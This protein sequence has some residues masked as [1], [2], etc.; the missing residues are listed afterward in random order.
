MTTWSIVA[1]PRNAIA[2]I[3]CGG[4]WVEAKGKKVFITALVEAEQEDATLFNNGGSLSF[5]TSAAKMRI[6]W[7]GMAQQLRSPNLKSSK[8]CSP[9]TQKN[10]A[11]SPRPANST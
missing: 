2:T 9:L 5:S 10:W 6:R 1:N 4:R 3:K 7:Y 8:M 11:H